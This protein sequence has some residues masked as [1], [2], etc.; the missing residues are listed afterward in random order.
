MTDELKL[1]PFCGLAELTFIGRDD[2]GDDKNRVHCNTCC[3]ETSITVWNTRTPDPVVEEL[4]EHCRNRDSGFLVI[5]VGS[6]PAWI[7]TLDEIL[8]RLNKKGG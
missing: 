3:F 8:S 1:C 5:S 6:A 4:V 2:W 7:K